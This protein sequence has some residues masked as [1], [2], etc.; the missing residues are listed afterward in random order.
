MPPRSP[1]QSSPQRRPPSHHEEEG[2]DEIYPKALMHFE[3]DEK[4][5]C[6]MRILL[7][8][9]GYQYFQYMTSR[10]FRLPPDYD[11]HQLIQ[12]REPI[13]VENLRNFLQATQ[14]DIQKLRLEIEPPKTSFVESI[15]ALPFDISLYMIPFPWDIEVPKYEKYDGNS[16]PHD[17]V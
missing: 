11:I 3:Q 5:Q 4:A 9:N 7:E 17:H 12:E 6:M 1:R 8:H 2:N 15:C 16:D 13:E 10:G 14:Q